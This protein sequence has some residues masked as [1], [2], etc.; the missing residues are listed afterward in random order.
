MIEIKKSELTSVLL[1]ISAYDKDGK[2]IG[3]LLL[4]NVSLGLKRRLQKIHTEAM[5]HYAQFEKDLAEAEKKDEEFENL[6]PQGVKNK[7]VNELLKEVV[8]LQSEK[9][10]LALI[11]GIVSENIYDSTLIEKFAE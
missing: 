6:N 8:K 9:A 3:G 1:T 5:T 2:M 4:E 7:E 11:D 10:S